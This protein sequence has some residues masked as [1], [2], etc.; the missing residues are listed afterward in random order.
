MNYPM[1]APTPPPTPGVDQADQLRRAGVPEE[2]IQQILGMAD[3]DPTGLA[4]MYDQS[5]YLRRGALAGDTAKN[6]GGVLAQGLMGYQASKVDKDYAEG[7]RNFRKGN[8]AGREAWF[9]HRYPQSI[10]DTPEAYPPFDE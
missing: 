10:S 9:R 6:I 5:A 3:N 2:L 4:K 7:L 8:R 1:P